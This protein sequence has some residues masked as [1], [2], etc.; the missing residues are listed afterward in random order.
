MDSN[1]LIIIGI[2]AVVVVVAIVLFISMN[3]IKKNGLVAEATVSRVDKETRSTVHDGTGMVDVD[4][5]ETF[6][7]KY[8]TESGE[9]VEAKLPNPAMHQVVGDTVK[10]KYLPEK[11][12]KVVRV[13]K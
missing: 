13:K 11:P 12:S 6:Y 2:V 5:Y 7:V 3:K 9:E 8:K 1:V 10:I 4:T